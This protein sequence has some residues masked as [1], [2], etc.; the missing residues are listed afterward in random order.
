MTFLIRKS[1][2]IQ[3]SE[4][5]LGQNQETAEVLASVHD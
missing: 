2:T 5:N 4:E 3:H 1:C